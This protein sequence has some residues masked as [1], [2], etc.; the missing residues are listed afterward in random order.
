MDIK[1]IEKKSPYRSYITIIDE[2][3]IILNRSYDVVIDE[4]GIILKNIDG[5]QIKC[6]K[7][8]QNTK[9][10][11]PLIET[12]K[13]NPHFDLEMFG[14]EMKLEDLVSS[15]P[16]KILVSAQSANDFDFFRTYSRILTREQIDIL[17]QCI[18]RNKDYN[19]LGATESNHGFDTETFGIDF[20]S[21]LNNGL[22]EYTYN[23][24]I[25]DKKLLEKIKSNLEIANYMADVVNEYMKIQHNIKNAPKEN[26]CYYSDYEYDPSLS[27]KENSQKRKELSE[28]NGRF[29]HYNE[30]EDDIAD[31]ESLFQERLQQL[32][33]NGKIEEFE[34]FEYRWSDYSDEV[35]TV[36]IDTIEEG[37]AMEYLKNSRKERIEV[38]DT[39]KAFVKKALKTANDLVIK[40]DEQGKDVTYLQSIL[41]QRIEEPTNA[42][43]SYENV[44]EKQ[45]LKDLLEA[46]WEETSHTDVMEG[47]RVFKCNL[48]GLKSILDLDELG[49][50]AELYA[51]DSKETG[52]IEIGA[53]NVTKKETQETYLITRKEMIDGVEKD[54]VFTFHPGEPVRPSQIKA[55]KIADGTRITVDK[56]KKLGLEK[57]KYLSEDMLQMYREKYE[58]EKP[59][60]KKFLDKLKG[61]FNK[62]LPSSSNENPASSSTQNSDRKK[63]FNEFNVEESE[64]QQ[65]TQNKPRKLLEDVKNNDNIE[66]SK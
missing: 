46:D 56:A 55:E 12:I 1:F 11:L 65:S 63:F 36:N 54:I 23:T 34:E 58:K 41:Q 22:D 24:I 3:G 35:V 31:L 10:L 53:G 26:F 44:T 32:D 7:N 52:N 51:I 5:R 64:L 25:Q 30:Y 21:K 45:L 38:T 4:L 39:D 15:N 59:F 19:F 20:I 61:L 16:S 28:K 2:L 33:Q 18:N 47:C 66:L 60:Y 43:S 6:I 50:N 17:K 42:S 62:K 13:V 40:K 9:Y 14:N 48:P 57:A 29:N 49:K 8:A 37:N 27:I